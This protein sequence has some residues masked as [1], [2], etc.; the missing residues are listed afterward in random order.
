M[1]NSPLRKI[2]N[3]AFIGDLRTVDE[4]VKKGCDIRGTD[5]Y[6]VTGLHYGAYQGD[7]EVL[8]YFVSK[9]CDVNVVDENGW[10][11][12]HVACQEGHLIVVE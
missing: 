12:I 6:G 4:L 2:L 11:G 9:G 7:V 10:N 1:D 3:A 8:D 5:E